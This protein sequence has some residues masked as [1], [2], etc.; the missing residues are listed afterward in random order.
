MERE[1]VAG[2]LLPGV[3][4]GWQVSGAIQDGKHV[5][6]VVHLFDFDATMT[7]TDD[8]AAALAIEVLMATCPDSRMAKFVKDGHAVLLKKKKRGN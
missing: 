7:L 5:G 2:S 6:V 4:R 3:S 8:E 1:G